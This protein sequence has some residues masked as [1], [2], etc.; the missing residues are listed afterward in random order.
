MSGWF[1]KLR[2]K[3]DASQALS[4]SR[5]QARTKSYSAAT[6]YVYQYVYLGQRAAK[7]GI[8]FAFDI[9]SDRTTTHRV[10]V[11]IADSAI[12][13]WSEST[14]REL[15]S[16]ER[17]AVAKLAL[18]NAFDE[19]EL[20]QLLSGLAPQADEVTAILEELGV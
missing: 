9:S 18:R 11:F 15:S 1:Q 2:R 19:Q 13:P 7:G 14:G 6:G 16:V 3:S 17:Y 10:T 20:E 8:H 5:A 4:G 12:A